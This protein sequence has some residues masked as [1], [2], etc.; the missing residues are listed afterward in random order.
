MQKEKKKLGEEKKTQAM[1]KKNF[2][3]L[4]DMNE[5][6]TPEDKYTEL[7]SDQEIED[8]IKIINKKYPNGVFP[9]H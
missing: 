6:E 9:Y 3:K 5:E 7:L 2:S 8:I 4:L 1:E